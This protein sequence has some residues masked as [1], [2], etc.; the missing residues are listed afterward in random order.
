MKNIGHFLLAALV[1][2]LCSRVGAGLFGVVIQ[3]A[4]LMTGSGPNTIFI[5]SYCIAYALGSALGPFVF[6]RIDKDRTHRMVFSFLGAVFAV[7][8]L[9]GGVTQNMWEYLPAP[10]G[11]GTIN[12]LAFLTARKEREITA[13]HE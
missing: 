4:W 3:T 13:N 2:G 7:F 5:V 9:I 1:G 12:I 8:Q 6:W 10:L 11:I